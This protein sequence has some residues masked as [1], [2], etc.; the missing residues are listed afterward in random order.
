MNPTSPAVP[1]PPLPGEANQGFAKQALTKRITARSKQAKPLANSQK[2]K[3]RF[4]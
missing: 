1:D 4:R 3:K 2:N